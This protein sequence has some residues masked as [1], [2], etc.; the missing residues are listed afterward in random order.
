MDAR[1]LRI[2]IE[3]AYIG[4]ENLAELYGIDPVDLEQVKTFLRDMEAQIGR[5][6]IADTTMTAVTKT[7]AKAKAATP[8]R[9]ID[10]ARMDAE[11]KGKGGAG[12]AGG[13]LFHQFITEISPQE[14]SRFSKGVTR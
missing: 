8:S 9:S 11:R 7:R 3:C 4:L 12:S 6:G 5:D 10:S 2:S 14:Y 1:D 13:R